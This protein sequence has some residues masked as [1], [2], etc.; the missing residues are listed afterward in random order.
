MLAATLLGVLDVNGPAESMD[1]NGWAVGC[2]IRG[3]AASGR[4]REGEITV[5]ESSSDELALK[6]QQL[7]Q[8]KRDIEKNLE[9]SR[10]EWSRA[11]RE[12]HSSREEH[13]AFMSA[14]EARCSRLR[15]LFA[16]KW[17]I[18]REMSRQVG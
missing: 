12:G 14:Y 4:R 18:E 2:P 3:N 8:V 13:T 7:E 5:T 1:S 6:R 16:E 11:I 9:D 15:E 17:Q 10:L